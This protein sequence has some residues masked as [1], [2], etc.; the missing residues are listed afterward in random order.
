MDIIY[1]RRWY[2][3]SNK[4]WRPQQECTTKW[5]TYRIFCCCCCV[6]CSCSDSLNNNNTVIVSAVAAINPAALQNRQVEENSW[7]VKL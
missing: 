7:I 3:M 4:G 5:K 1:K 2:L 6:P